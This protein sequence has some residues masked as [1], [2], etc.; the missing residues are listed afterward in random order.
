MCIRDRTGTAWK[1]N[2]KTRSVDP[3]MYVSSFIGM[4]PADDPEIVIAVVMDEPRGGARDGGVVSAPVF[5]EVAQHMLETMKI[6]KDAPQKP[7]SP[8][9][10]VIPETPQAVA[11]NDKAVSKNNT[12]ESKPSLAEKPVESIEKPKVPV[13]KPVTRKGKEE[14][15]PPAERPRQVKS[16]T[17]K[18]KLET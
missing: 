15:K 8:I 4:A 13:K 11:P 3:S 1:V 16:G 17:D 9:A 14:D 2:P 10:E 6:R 7:E 12:T 18:T 5:R